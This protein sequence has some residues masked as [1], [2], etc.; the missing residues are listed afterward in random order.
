MGIKED[1]E[2]FNETGLRGLL[3]RIMKE[4]DEA[5]IKILNGGWKG[6]EV[7]EK[8][9]PGSGPYLHYRKG[10]SVLEYSN[11]SPTDSGYKNFRIEV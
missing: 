6:V 5:F 3:R 1:Q 2:D 9:S 8:P 4:K 7:P 10:Y 11:E